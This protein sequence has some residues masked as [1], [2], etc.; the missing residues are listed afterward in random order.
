MTDLLF[1][2][3][4]ATLA[5]VTFAWLVTEARACEQALPRPDVEFDMPGFGVHVVYHHLDDTTPGRRPVDVVIET[6]HG[7]TPCELTEGGRFGPSVMHR[8]VIDEP[9]HPGD[10][11]RIGLMPSDAL[12]TFDYCPEVHA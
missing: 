7:S 5:A 11:L 10:T 1:L 3:A 4:A 12:L 6:A 9:L 8:W 2:T